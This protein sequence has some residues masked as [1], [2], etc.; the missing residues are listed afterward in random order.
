ME[1]KHCG[2]FAIP[3]PPPPLWERTHGRRT[4]EDRGWRETDPSTLDP[5]S[6]PPPPPRGTANS[7]NRRKT[8]AKG[9]KRGGD[10]RREKGGNVFN[11]TEV[12]VS[13][14]VDFIQRLHYRNVF[15]I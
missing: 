6:L 10:L 4:V 8:P 9:G 3:I 2:I 15:Y 11:H 13:P 7:A 5:P 12:I 14:K 1:Q